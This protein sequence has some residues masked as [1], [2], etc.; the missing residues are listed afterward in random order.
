MIVYTPVLFLLLSQQVPV[1]VCSLV[2]QRGGPT[3]REVWMEGAWLTGYHG[4]TIAALSPDRR[5]P[6]TKCEIVPIFHGTLE[7]FRGHLPDPPPIEGMK[8]TFRD[9][10]AALRA[11]ANPVI[12]RVRG[13]L[14][15]A[16]NFKMGKNGGGNGF[17]HNWANPFAIVVKEISLVRV[18]KGG[19]S[20]QSVGKHRFRQLAK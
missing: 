16:R 11:G 6:D 3:E 20:V 14:H 15:V 8:A 5:S 1:D 2:S 19:P 13:R 12:V 10:N 4:T 17:G 9:I 18:G 7:A